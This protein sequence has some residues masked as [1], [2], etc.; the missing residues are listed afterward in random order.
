M[1]AQGA[2]DLALSLLWLKLLLWYR[3]NT[4]PRHSKL[5]PPPKKNNTQKPTPTV[6]RQ[7]KRLID[8]K[9]IVEVKLSGFPKI[10]NMGSKGAGL[11]R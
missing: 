11:S 2:K 10:L 6:Y 7:K 1:R 5:P 4:W 8:L 9:S 3:F